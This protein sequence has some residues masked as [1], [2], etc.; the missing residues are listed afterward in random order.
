MEQFKKYTTQDL[1]KDYTLTE[2]QLKKEWVKLHKYNYDTNKNSFV[3]NNIIYHYQI[4]NLIKTKRKNKHSFYEYMENE[5]LYNKLWV[6]TKKRNRTGT[7]PKKLFQAHQINNGSICFF[8]AGQ[9]AYLYK[10]Y[11]AESV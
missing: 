2:E 7:I 3:G 10:K 11:G 1:I 4:K 8:K 5:T 6:Q 9:S